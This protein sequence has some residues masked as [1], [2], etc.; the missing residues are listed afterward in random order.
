VDA[1][2]QKQPRASK[3]VR[4]TV[5]DAVMQKQLRASKHVRGTAVDAVMQKQPRASKHVRGTAVDAV[6]QKQPRASKHVRGTAVDAVMQ[7][8]PRASK[9]ARGTAVDAV[10][11]KQLRASKHARGTTVD[12]QEDPVRFR[13]AIILGSNDE[14]PQPPWFRLS[15]PVRGTTAG[16]EETFSGKWFSRYLERASSV[17]FSQLSFLLSVFLSV[18]DRPVWAANPDRSL[19]TD[20][21]ASSVPIYFFL[22]WIVS[23]KP[24]RRWL[25]LRWRPWSER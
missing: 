22:Q 21:V 23:S 15:M 8:Q 16:T 4:G 14:T 24:S 1:V 10:M 19:I 18:T 5:V 17:T 13:H 2:M 12:I 3:H 25:L 9:H 7:K 20:L 6:M 11:Q